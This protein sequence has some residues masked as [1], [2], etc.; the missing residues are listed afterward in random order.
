MP[1]SLEI[2]GG[3]VFA[4]K[5]LSS[6]SDGEIHLLQPQAFLHGGMAAG[7]GFVSSSGEEKS[8]LLIGGNGR[9]HC[10]VVLPAVAAHAR[11]SARLASRS[12]MRRKV[13]SARVVFA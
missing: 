11:A 5:S 6:A 4:I 12:T 3:C 7:A 13:L 2:A 1:F 9:R 8:V 10:W